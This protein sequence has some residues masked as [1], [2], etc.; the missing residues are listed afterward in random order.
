MPVLAG[1]DTTPCPATTTPTGAQWTRE[2]N[3]SSDL[4]LAPTRRS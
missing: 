3:D 2:S 1:R 4:T